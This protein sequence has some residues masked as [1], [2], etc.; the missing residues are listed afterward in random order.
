MC[1][2]SEVFDLRVLCRFIFASFAHVCMLYMLCVC[3]CRTDRTLMVI[4]ARIPY[5]TICSINEKKSAA[6]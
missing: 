5:R 4:D 6:D 3:V 1:V 2:D